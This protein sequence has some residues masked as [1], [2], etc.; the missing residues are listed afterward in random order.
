MTD[1]D[2][3]VLPSDVA[4]IRE[5][6]RKVRDLTESER[7]QECIRLWHKHDL[8]QCERPLIQTETDGGLQM[9]VGDYHCRTQEPWAQN[10]EWRL[11]DRIV[12]HEIIQ[13]DVPLEPFINVGWNLSLGGYG[14]DLHSTQPQTDGTRGAYHIDAAL[15]DLQRDFHKLRPRTYSVD[16]DSTL[17]NVALLQDVYGDILQVRIRS[18]PWWTLGMTWTAIT[19]VGLEQFML[20]MYD[21][22]QALHQLMAFLRDDHLSLVAWMEKEGL[23]GLNNA[24]DYIGSGSRGYT[25]RLPQADYPAGG[26]ARSKDLWVL[27]ESQ[28]TVGVGPDLYAEFV[29]PYENAIAQ[30]FGGVYYGCCEPVHTRWH[31]LKNLANL[32]RVSVSPWC[33]EEFM[34]A[35]L[36]NKYVYSRKPKPTLVST[37][38]FDEELIRADL[39]HTMELA[40]KH[41]CSLE[42]DMKDVHT[43]HGE[44]DR[45]TRWVKLAREETARVY[46]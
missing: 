31:V 11:L 12:H 9:V 37:E 20:Y 43:L 42:I 25:P 17:K 38:K 14:V 21:Q 41:G 1:L 24:N 46:G 23:L 40:Q 35:E 22:P 27:L 19:L 8:C 26:P 10:E 18:N 5:M 30:K 15:E 7:N 44:R 4:I 34:A 29:F 16:R 28:E 2:L 39:R 36:S 13:D 33:D 32:K 3:K 6:A 45:L